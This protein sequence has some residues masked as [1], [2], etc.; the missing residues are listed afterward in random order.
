MR[1]NWKVTARTG[2]LHSMAYLSYL[3]APVLIVLNLTRED[4]PARYRYHYLERAATVAAS[5]YTGTTT[6]KSA[7]IPA[8]S[9]Q[10]FAHHV[11]E[12]SAYEYKVPVVLFAGSCT[13][14]H[15]ATA[16]SRS[17]SRG[18]LQ[19]IALGPQQA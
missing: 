19:A 15:H 17:Q 8:A 7:L 13:R 14:A 3:R 2:K 10:G 9:A 18:A 16:R 12:V 5:L 6:D 4:Y 11:L 1:I